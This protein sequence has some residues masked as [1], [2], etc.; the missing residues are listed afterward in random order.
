MSEKLNFCRPSAG[1]EELSALRATIKKFCLDKIKPEIRNLEKKG[2]FPRALY[3]ELGDI[4]AFGCIFSPEIGGSDMGFEALSIVSEELAYC[5]PPI[6]AAMNLQAA[7][8][9]LTIQNWGP[10]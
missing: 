8:V 6:S 9:P 5:Y 4:G 2:D 1:E 7:T 3:E 10:F